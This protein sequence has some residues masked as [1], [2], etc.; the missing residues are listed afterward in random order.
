VNELARQVRR[1]IQ[2]GLALDSLVIELRSL[3]A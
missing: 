3:T 2:K 1:N